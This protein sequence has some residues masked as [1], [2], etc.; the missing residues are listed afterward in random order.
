MSRFVWAW[1]ESCVRAM[2]GAWEQSGCEVRANLG[3]WLRFGGLSATRCLVMLMTACSLSVGAVAAPAWAASAGGSPGRVSSGARVAPVDAVVL[4]MGS[5]CASG[6]PRVRGLQRRLAGA[7][8]S[9]GPVDGCYGPQTEDAVARFQAARGLGVDGTAGRV[10]LAA[11][12]RRSTVLYPGAGYTGHGLGQVRALQRRLREAGFSP[13]PIDGRYGPRTEKAVARFQAAHGLGVDGTAGPETFTGLEKDRVVEPRSAHRTAR[14]PTRAHGTS[15]GS[16][17]P[18]RAPQRAVP[19]APHP[20]PGKASGSSSTLLWV[21][22]AVLGVGMI[23]IGAWV[24]GA[25][26]A[27]RADER[28]RPTSASN[29]VPGA[30]LAVPDARRL[31]P[32]DH[33]EAVAAEA[34][35]READERRNGVGTSNLGVLLEPRDGLA[36]AADRRADV[37]RV[38]NGTSNHAGL[39]AEPGELRSAEAGYRQADERADADAASNLGLLL[40]R[41]TDLGG[42]EAAYRRADERGDPDGAFCL[43]GMLADRGNLAAAMAAYRRAHQRG[44]PAAASNLGVLLEQNGD[45]RGAEAAYQRAD[46][47][48]DADG[49]FNLGGLLADRGD[50]AAAMAAYRRADE[51][52]HRAAAS[53]V[54]V[55]LEYAGDLAGAEAAYRRAGEHGNATGVF[56]HGQLLEKQGLLERAL[57]AYERARRLGDP[58]IAEMASARARELTRAARTTATA[59]G[60]RS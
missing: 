44:H 13:G 52:G 48:G 46:D 27:P 59:T 5:G 38:A 49:A 3:G 53:N 14:Q 6:S 40:E 58:E 21:V 11:L 17:P 35:Y 12:L 9:P 4:R 24:D 34:A 43:G 16:Q 55:L 29:L 26:L 36:D 30:R 15:P 42:A 8:F 22:L 20:H 32:G 25:R 39:L 2:R 33:P 51:R 56:N 19:P 54:G 10:T 57:T 7:G 41:S 23:G 47:L 1:F 50:L 60:G 28:K 45:L 31:P 18:A 37:R